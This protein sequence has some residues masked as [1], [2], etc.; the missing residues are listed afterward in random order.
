MHEL[1]LFLG[2]YVDDPDVREA[3]VALVDLRV[4]A[5]LPRRVG[6]LREGIDAQEGDPL[7]VRRPGEAGHAL[8]CIGELLRLTTF[9]AQQVNLRTWLFV[10]RHRAARRQEGD[11]RAV[12]RPL[13]LRFTALTEGDLSCRS[14]S[15]C[16]DEPEM[17]AHLVFV[18]ARRVAFGRVGV[19]MFPCAHDV[20][21]LRPVRRDG[22]TADVL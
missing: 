11:H 8:L 1:R 10:A 22:D 18:A 4:V 19:R 12:R 7:P 14:R 13:R 2:S 3:E 9:E 20:H 6:G 5:P 21:D 16:R 15:V 17:R